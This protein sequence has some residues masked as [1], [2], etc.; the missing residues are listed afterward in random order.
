MNLKPSQ[1]AFPKGGRG[2]GFFFRYSGTGFAG[3]DVAM[4]HSKEKGLPFG[5]EERGDGTTG[6]LIGV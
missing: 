4:T 6:G 5:R 1:P 2:G 3:D